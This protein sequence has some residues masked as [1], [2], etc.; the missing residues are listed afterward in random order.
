MLH[1][2]LLSALAIAQPLY[3]L[4]GQ[5]P[6][7]LVAH[8]MTRASILLSVLVLSIGIPAVLFVLYRLG[9]AL[10]ARIGDSV[11]LILIIVLMT[12]AALPVCVKWLHLDGSW[13][14][15]AAAGT[16]M[17]VSGLY[18]VS[19]VLRLFLSVFSF[20]ALAFP[21]AFLLF[22]PANELLS[23]ATVKQ[24]SAQLEVAA[25]NPVFI[26]VFDEF[27]TLSILDSD[28]N[29]DAGRFPVLAGLQQEAVWYR[30][31]S[32]NSNSTL[33][34][35]PALL[36][37]NMPYGRQRGLPT[38]EN[39]P[40]NIFALL[41]RSYSVN[42]FEHATRLCP[43]SV[44][45]AQPNEFNLLISDTWILL[46]NIITPPAWARYL[47][48][49]NNDW[50][51]FAAGTVQNP[52]PETIRGF[53]KTLNW[54]ARV[55][56][57]D[58]F[59]NS[60]TA[61]PGQLYYFHTMLPH[62]SW[63]YLPD[64]R[65]FVADETGAVLGSRE[66]EPGMPF[67]HMWYDAPNAMRT[68]R[69]R[70][71]LQVGLVDTLIG[72]FL[73]RLKTLGIYEQSLV[74]L[75]S[76]HGISFQP[77][78]TRRS[79]YEGNMVEISAVPLLIK[80]PGN[81]PA[82]ISEVNS[83]AM[84][85]IPTV[86]DALDAGG[87]AEYDG[88]SLLDANAERPVEKILYETFK[89]RNATQASEHRDQLL[90]K[91]LLFSSEYGEG[92]YVSLYRAGD[93]YGLVGSNVTDVPHTGTAG[94]AVELHRSDLYQQVQLSSAFIPLLTHGRLDAAPAALESTRVA[95][96]VN[97]VIRA[98]T[99]LLQIPGR[100][101]EFEL[102]LP[103]EAFV[104]GANEVEAWLVVETSAGP[105]L[106][107]LVSAGEPEYALVTNP[108][109]STILSVNNVEIE[110]EHRAVIGGN[111]AIS[112][113]SD[114]LLFLSGWAADIE[115]GV[116]AESVV[117]FLDGIF[118]AALRPQRASSNV[119]NRFDEPGLA[120]CGFRTPIAISQNGQA[121]SME[122]RIFAISRDQRASE[123]SYPANPDQWPF[124]VKSSR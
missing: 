69:Q 45:G 10:A 20:A 35:L 95:V 26:L 29:I 74:V 86:L 25:D 76:D 120:N 88:L 2:G 110:I 78:S 109:G 103:P 54:R 121:N 124:K 82:G 49:V 38:E 90:Q 47:H 19:G 5:N 115:N 70:H 96:S 16:G 108:D 56:A 63:K 116:A 1:L 28:M 27:P 60:I 123:L 91:A 62:A 39:F 77:G 113:D 8:N 92:D 80:F 87:W 75:T 51:N 100:G 104:N 40:D 48:P 111:Q 122:V 61:D 66:N 84:D 72:R 68:N 117:I 6:E 58:E 67:K 42:A 23:G 41:G 31:H 30:N 112:S 98:V 119:A 102:L 36:S 106:Q 85:I 32:A 53:Q 114:K 97:G 50:K 57:F 4:I 65:L 24:G 83:Q 89:T 46:T 94:P 55:R 79:V 12:I 99:G 73:D 71:V 81:S 15:L 7:F 17:L 13:A 52:D 93:E 14:L 22:S 3:S 64:G 44:C 33:I 59:V 37:G 34:A 105:A 107:R 118:Y 101:N 11:L 43:E 18:Q 9:A 21:I